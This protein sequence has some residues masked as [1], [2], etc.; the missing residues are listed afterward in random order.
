MNNQGR[1]DLPTSYAH[2]DLDSTGNSELRV[3]LY[4]AAKL[5]HKQTKHKERKNEAFQVGR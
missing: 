4:E 5:D 2:I 3:P 1:Y